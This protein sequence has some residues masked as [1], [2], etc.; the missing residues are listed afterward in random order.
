MMKRYIQSEVFRYLFTGVLTTIV[1]FITFII[2]TAR[3]I[4]YDYKMATTIAWIISVAFAFFMNKWYVFD[5]KSVN[6]YKAMKEFFSFFLYRIFSLLL[7]L[8]AMFV[9]IEVFSISNA[10]SKLIANIFVILF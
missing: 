2:C 4:G 8:L 10:L 6:Q 5:S 9:L 3:A 7:D 1:N